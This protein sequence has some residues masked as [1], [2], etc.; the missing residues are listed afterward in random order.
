[1]VDK[2]ADVTLNSGERLSLAG[3]K[4]IDETRFNQLPSEVVLA[5]RERGWLGLIYAHLISVNSW[6]GLIDRLARRGAADLLWV[7]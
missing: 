2:R 7:A 3:F 1:M 4:V 5:W 6:T